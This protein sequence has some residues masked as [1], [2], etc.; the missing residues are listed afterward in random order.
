MAKKWKAYSWPNRVDDDTNSQPP[1]SASSD[2]ASLSPLCTKNSANI[3]TSSCGSVVLSGRIEK[4]S[5]QQQPPRG[6]SGGKSNRNAAIGIKIGNNEKHR[7]EDAQDTGSISGASS[8]TS[9]S[10][11]NISNNKNPSNY[12]P[13]SESVANATTTTTIITAPCSG[14]PPPSS[15]AGAVGISTIAAAGSTNCTGAVGV[16]VAGAVEPEED[17][18]IDVV[19]VGPATNGKTHPVASSTT[20]STTSASCWGPSSPTVSCRENKI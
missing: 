16:V 19:G 9:T 5:K 1:L 6:K 8:N 12:N 15:A 11:N 20:T 4:Q 18:E 13:P 3:S 10:N 7:E 14:P 2:A 17:E